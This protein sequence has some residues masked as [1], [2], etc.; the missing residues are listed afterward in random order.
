MYYYRSVFDGI[1]ALLVGFFTAFSGG[2]E[3]SCPSVNQLMENAR[4][5]RQLASLH[6][7]IL[8]AIQASIYQRVYVQ[9]MLRYFFRVGEQI[10]VFLYFYQLG[11]SIWHLNEVCVEPCHTFDTSFH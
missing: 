7:K 5:T 8:I 6:Q 4:I 11:R 1:A 3:G 10:E 9:L 2:T